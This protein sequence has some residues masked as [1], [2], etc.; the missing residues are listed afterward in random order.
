MRA[1]KRRGRDDI[2]LH[3]I[4]DGKLK[5]GL[6]KRAAREE[7]SNCVF[8][9][10]VPKTDLAKQLPGYD[11]GLMILANVPAFYYGTSPN[12]VFDYIAA[13]LPVLNNYPGW[14]ADMIVKHDCGLTVSPDNPC[15]F[16]DALERLADDHAG[17]RRQGANAR[18]L[19]EEEF[20]RRHLARQFAEC[21]ESVASKRS[22]AP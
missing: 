16:A 7:L 21:L 14:L 8:H 13:G 12:K 10:P 19:A 22:G 1:L 18:Q 3:F 6:V 4:G 15:A 17:R 9:D 20:D 11:A 5:A 2:E